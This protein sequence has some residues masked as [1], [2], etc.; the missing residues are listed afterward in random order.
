MHFEKRSRIRAPASAVFAFHERPDALA[1]LTPPWEKMDVVQPPGSLAVGTVVK[2]RAHVGPLRMMIVAEH[3][4]YD[5]GRSFTDRMVR[6]P[7]PE[8]LHRH[9]V[10]PETDASC[11]L[12]DDVT[13]T[14]PLGALGARVAGGMVRR[15]LDRMFAFRHEVTRAAC[16]ATPQESTSPR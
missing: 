2:L 15:R 14:L 1:R 3:V 4:A 16:E 10:I 5:A 6:G 12:V 9:V 13:Y 8:W 11:F 7:F